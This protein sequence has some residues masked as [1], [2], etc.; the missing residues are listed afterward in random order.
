ME[1]NRVSLKVPSNP[2]F[3]SLVRKVVGKAAELVGFGE[4]EVC[5]VQLAVTEAC[6]NIIRHSYHNDY[7]QE[8][9]IEVVLT[10]EGISMIL[11]DRGEDAGDSILKPTKTIDL[12]PGGL[13][14][15][16][17]HKC[18]NQV[19]YERLGDE[20]NRLCMVKRLNSD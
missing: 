19:A 15:H 8:I 10:E 13:G 11:K 17:I 9:E 14:V 12:S 4:K 16:L 7:D 2:K 20:K 5:Q 18:M 1:E 6:S 3:L